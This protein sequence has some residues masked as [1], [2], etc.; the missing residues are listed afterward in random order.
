METLIN[1]PFWWVLLIMIVFGAPL[2]EELWFRGFLFPALAQSKLGVAGAAMVSS[3]LWAL[4]HLGY[5]PQVLVVVFVDWTAA[6]GRA[7]TFGQPVAPH[8]LPRHL[9]R[10][11][12]RLFSDA[13]PAGAGLSAPNAVRGRQR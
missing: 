8:R 10:Q 4:L 5:P 6:D 9:Q 12:V 7:V 11:F 1:S 13:D 2:F 3:G